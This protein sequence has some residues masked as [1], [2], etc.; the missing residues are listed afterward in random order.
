[1]AERGREGEQGRQ[2]GRMAGVVRNPGADSLPQA[3]GI[4]PAPKPSERSHWAGP[5]KMAWP[6]AFLRV[7]ASSV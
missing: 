4:L 6:A 7:E 3:L 2:G 5:W 1:M